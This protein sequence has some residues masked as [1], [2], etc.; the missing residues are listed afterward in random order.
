MD[1]KTTLYMEKTGSVVR[2]FL[3]LFLLFLPTITSNS[4]Q[5]IGLDTEEAEVSDRT[6]LT[7]TSETLGCMKGIAVSTH[8]NFLINRATYWLG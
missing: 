4:F 3:S 7:K 6:P 5:L 2:I 8:C 1:L